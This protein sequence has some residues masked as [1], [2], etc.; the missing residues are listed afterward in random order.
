MT[1]HIYLRKYSDELV[2]HCR[3]AEG[4]VAYPLQLGCPW[5]GCGWMFSCINCGKG[6]T[7][8]TAILIDEPWESLAARDLQDRLQAKPSEEGIRQWVAFMKSYLANAE[9]GKTYVTFDGRLIPEYTPAICFDGWHSR[10]N[11]AFVPQVEAL[12]DESI[13]DSILTNRDYW[14]SRSI[15]Q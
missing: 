1:K 8:A 7:F 12:K 2:S 15:A 10:H 13:M 4:L 9:A 14:K 3:C 11:I 5:C 6:F